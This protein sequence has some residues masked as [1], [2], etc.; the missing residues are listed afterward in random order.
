MTHFFP[1]SFQN[2]GLAV[3]PQIVGAIGDANT[4]NGHEVRGYALQLVFFVIVAL[5]AAVLVCFYY[6]YLKDSFPLS[7]FFFNF[8]SFSPLPLVLWKHLP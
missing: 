6:Y 8:L 5:V 4:K 7:F 1:F 2:L 3:F